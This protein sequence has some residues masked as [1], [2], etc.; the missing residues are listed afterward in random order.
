MIAVSDWRLIQPKDWRWLHFL[1]QSLACKDDGSLTVDEL[2]L[3]ELEK[4]RTING[5]EPLVVSS[6]WR[7]PAYN[8]KVSSTGLTGPHTTGMA[9][10]ILCFGTKAFKLLNLA[11]GMKFTGIGLSQKGDQATRFLHLDLIPPGSP[12]NTR[13]WV[14]SY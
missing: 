14:W 10:D 13:P 5:N 8:A 7:T 12:L 9:V 4:L 11:L 6:C 3:D 1:P 2:L